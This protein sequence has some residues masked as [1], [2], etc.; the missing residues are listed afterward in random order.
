[1]RAHLKGSPH[2]SGL[3]QGREGANN[4]EGNDDEA[5]QPGVMAMWPVAHLPHLRTTS[6]HESRSPRPSERCAINVEHPDGA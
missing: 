6:A 2:Q 3:N 5:D 4:Q 1:M